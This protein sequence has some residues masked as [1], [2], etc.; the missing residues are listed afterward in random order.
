MRLSRFPYLRQPTPAGFAIE[1]MAEKHQ[2]NGG[3]AFEPLALPTLSSSPRCSTPSLKY[4]LFT[5][6]GHAL[7]AI[8]LLYSFRWF[9]GLFED[10]NTNHD[11]SHDWPIQAFGHH[12]H[13]HKHGLLNGHH[14]EQIFLQVPDESS[15][16]EASRAYAGLPHLAGSDQDL[17][18]A[19]YVLDHFQQTFNIEPPS[20]EPIF[21]A[22]SVESRNATLNIPHNKE[23]YAWIDTY[24]PVMNTPLNHSLEILDKDGDVAWTAQLEEDCEALD[25]DAAN[26]C[27]V[28]TAFHGLSKA[29]DVT[30]ELFYANYGTP[31][32]YAA[33]ERSGVNITGK[34]ALVRYG[35]LFRGL[36]IKGAEERGAIGVLIYSDPRDDGSVVVENGYKPYPHG[37]ARHP[38][39]VQRGSVQFLSFYPGD[40]TTPGYPAYENS[41]RTNGSNIPFIPSL[42]IS[43]S[44]AKVLLEEIG[45]DGQGRA[46]RLVNQVDTKPTPIWNTMALIPGHIGD[47]VVV[48]GNHR[49]AWVLGAADPSSG[50]TAVHEVIRGLGAL[51]R[52]GWKPLRSILL[53][54]WDAEEY[55]L[56]GS[57]EWGEDFPDW[58]KKHVVAY[59]NMDV[60]VMGSRFGAQASPSL[61]YLIRQAADE[62]PHPT[63]VG[64]SLWDATADKGP[65]TG[66]ADAAVVAI[67]EAKEKMV[68]TGLGV[69][70]LGSGSDF[71]VFLQRLGI[72]SSD[73]GF[74]ATLSDAVY[75]YHSIYDSQMFQEVYADPGFHRH[76]AI[77]KYLGLVVL[78]LADSIILPLNT[79]HYAL[80]LQ[81]YL[82]NVDEIVANSQFE[83]DLTS[84]RHAIKKLHRASVKLD[85]EKADAEE[86]L[87]RIIRRWQRRHHGHPHGHT[88]HCNSRWRRLNSWVK[89][90]FWVTDHRTAEEE[91]SDVSAHLPD[92]EHRVH[93]LDSP[94]PPL[95]S[96]SDRPHH[97]HHRSRHPSHRLIEAVKRVRAVNKKLSSFE[98]GFISEGGLIEREWYKHLVVAPGRWLGYGATTLPGL[99]EALTIDQSSTQAKHEAKRLT[100][101]IKQLAKSI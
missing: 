99:T 53:A 18:T 69:T 9:Y 8:G 63:R 26:A 74:A 61:A 36:K 64:S 27:D 68:E 31:E 71:T 79:T 98:S 19:K 87:R 50:T 11:A 47:E 4:R 101:L 76:V 41:T 73:G 85:K 59:V 14:A 32:D 93:D 2:Q 23:P 21:S 39:S 37:P 67:A 82:N 100:K 66:P 72:A 95:L 49:D 57:T 48:L 90:I 16:I 17:V 91:G 83:V 3:E 15:A 97:P 43:W 29:G 89:S 78:R 54:S 86:D 6:F 12:R 75:H 7:F 40:P 58:I 62:V 52:K 56:I 33:V 30:G 35:G 96:H 84:L 46:V 77:S 42:P 51:Y 20:V 28:V 25:E 80:E 1:S 22:G 10:K 88:H 45:K 81:S 44:T 34:I 38:T 94:S 60:A 55:G 5:R 92:A 24:Y 65:F 13:G 70:P